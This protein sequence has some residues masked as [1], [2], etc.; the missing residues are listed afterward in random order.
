MKCLHYKLVLKI[1]RYFSVGSE[2]IKNINTMIHHC[3][4]NY[5]CKNKNNRKQMMHVIVCFYKHKFISPGNWVWQVSNTQFSFISKV[6]IADA[7]I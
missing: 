6:E 2:K 5:A 7:K 4:F 1:V 3:N